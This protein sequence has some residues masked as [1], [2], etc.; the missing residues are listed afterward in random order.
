[1]PEYT[2]LTE[3]LLEE[4][5]GTPKTNAQKIMSKDNILGMDTRYQN[6]IIKDVSKAVYNND[7]DPLKKYEVHATLYNTTASICSLGYGPDF[8]EIAVAI[9]K[10][11]DP[12]VAIASLKKAIKV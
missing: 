11:Q 12:K 4:F 9:T 5:L 8:E 6:D 7:E 2:P 1:L 10:A 3:E